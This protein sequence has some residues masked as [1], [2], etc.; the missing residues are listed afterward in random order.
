MGRLA[1][2]GMSFLLGRGRPVGALSC[3]LLGILT[4][5]VTTLADDG[6]LV[7]VERGPHHSVVERRILEPGARPTAGTVQR[8]VQL[9][10]GLN[11]WDESKAS[12]R[13]SVEEVEL[14][15]AGAVAARG[16]YRAQFSPNVNDPQ[17]AARLGFPGAP[18]L[19][20]SVLALRYFDPVTGKDVVLAVVQDAPGGLLAPNQVIY[21]NAFD[22]LQAD[23]LYTY[24]KRGFE[25]DV[26]LREVPPSPGEFGLDPETTR[27]EVLTEFFEAPDPV[28]TPR[29]LASIEDPAWR[30]AVAQPDWVD[31]ELDFGV[32]RMVAGR[33]FAWSAREAAA[34]RPSEFSPVGKRWVRTGDGRTVLIESTEYS[35]LVADL[36]ALPGTP[37]R[38]QELQRTAAAWA[39]RGVAAGKA[40]VLARAAARSSSGARAASNGAGTV[41]VRRWA[42]VER[43]D[44]AGEQWAMGRRE[45]TA[46][47]ERGLVLDWTTL[48]NGLSDF[49]FLGTNT[50]Y[51]TGDCVFTGTTTLEGGAVLKFPKYTNN[52]TGITING[53]WV[54]RASLF[55]PA[56][57]TADTDGTM[58]EIVVA[59]SPD[60][61]ADYGATQLKFLNRGGPIQVEHLRFKY[62]RQ[63]LVFQGDNPDNLVRHCQFVQCRFPVLSTTNTPVRLRNVLVDGVKSLGSIFSGAN[64]PFVGEQLTLHS[65][66]NLLTGGTLVLTNSLVVAVSTVQAYT[67]AG[68]H[69]SASATG[70]FHSQGAGNF[71]LAVGSPHRDAGV[72]EIHAALAQELAQLTTHPPVI[73]TSDFTVDTVLQPQAK[74]DTGLPDRGYHYPPLDYL[75][76]GRMLANVQLRLTNG[77]ALGTYGPVGILLGRGGRLHSAGTPAALNRLVHYGMVQEQAHPTWTLAAGDIALLELVPNTLSPIT[78]ARLVFTDVSMP[79]GPAN[80]R[81][82]LRQPDQGSFALSATHSQVRG[83]DLT[84]MTTQPGVS[85]ALTNSLLEGTSLSL[86]Q[87][88]LVGNQAIDFVAYNNLFRGGAVVLKSDR[89]DST[90]VVRDN[91]F[92]VQTLSVAVTVGTLSHNGFRAGLATFGTSATGG[93]TMDFAAS[94][95]GPYTYPTSGPANSLA[96]LRDA[97]SRGG[98]A[99]GLYLFTTRTDQIPE[100]NSVVDIGFHYAGMG[101]VDTD[102][103]LDVVEDGDG[104][105]VADAGETSYVA[106]DTDYDGRSDFQE[107]QEGTDPLNP[108]SAKPMK[109]ATWTFDNLSDPWKTEAGA[110]P[111]E[112][113]GVGLVETI[114]GFYGAELVSANAVLRYREVEPGG[115]ANINTRQ[116]TIKLTF[117]PYWASALSSC[118]VGTAGTGP[119]TTIELLSVGAFSVAVDPKGTNLMLRSPNGSGGVLTNVQTLL[120]ACVGDIPVDFPLEVQVSYSSNASAIFYNGQLVAR[121]SGIVAWPDAAT[122]ANGLFL[123]T[124]PNRTGQMNGVIDGL[125]TY[126]VPLNMHTNTWIVTAQAGA[127]PLR[128]IL[129]WSGLTNVNYRIERRTVPLTQWVTLA[130]LPPPIYTD[131]TVL[132][133]REYEYRVSADVAVPEEFYAA[134]D[135]AYAT[136]HAGV[137]L[138][139]DDLPGH[140]LLVVDRTLTNNP[141]YEAAVTN[142]TRDL[143][144]EGWVVARYNGPRHDDTTWA[145]NPARIA[146]VK[147]WI[148]S[149][150]NANARLARAVLLFGHLPIPRSG[151][152]RPDAHFYRPFPADTYYADLDGNWTDVGNWPIQPGVEAPNLPGDGIF[153]QEL[154]P[155]NSVGIAGV[156]LAVGRVDFARMPVF[157][158]GSPSRGEVDLLVQYV[159][160]SR[161]FRRRQVTLP[162]RVVYRPY[163]SAT[164]ALDTPEAM[165]LQLNGLPLSM[166]NL[167]ERIDV[168]LTGTNSNAGIYADFF[169]AGQPAIWGIQGG[170]AGGVDWIHSD[171]NVRTLHGITFHSSTNLVSASG[172]PPIAFSLIEMS[173]VGQWD[174]PNHLARALMGTRTN[175]LA[176]LNF[177]TVGTYWKLPMMALGR[178]LGDAYKQTLDDAWTRPFLSFRI[179]PPFGTDVKYYQGIRS[180]GGY[181][182]TA[183]LGDPTLRQS[184]AT[185]VSS[186]TVSTNGSGHLVFQWSPTTDPFP[187]YHLYRT[188]EAIGGKWQRMT[189]SPLQTTNWTDT[190]P[191]VGTRRYM[192]RPLYTKSVASGSY[193]NMGAGTIWP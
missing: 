119:G 43:R 46:N 139:P 37:A 127:S 173:W 126:N 159:N 99:A 188:T 110:D 187:R 84:V 170:Y 107:Y 98:A 147:S 62:G 79:A 172:E 128:V 55:R 10:T 163:F 105:G 118:A 32:H 142:L 109:L 52:V 95:L 156:E 167:G 27:L 160:K 59:G 2:L 42:A 133:G 20:A 9:E 48:I 86:T 25:A 3:L 102:G 125:Q 97:G 35:G 180:Q 12:W 5:V 120:R 61:T 47:L 111:V 8:W 143:A 149:Y 54:N 164:P 31:E 153:D 17:G 56:I 168:A 129:R 41:P 100:T 140:L 89:P 53:T 137:R 72:A 192:V 28:A 21:Q 23:V 132:L 113:T 190:A 193:T 63:A 78:E 49:T 151:M 24:R 45:R 18:E 104:D 87:S 90:W 135:P 74:R 44:G 19:R 11:Y 184:P 181:A 103:I 114:P 116:G 70:L 39:G 67:G 145:N 88:N 175:G 189:L 101:D 7:I 71:Y 15:D 26:V 148:T 150:R 73:V 34:D 92:D 179:S 96:S 166:I 13:E 77:V 138:P 177:G 30:A 174:E 117:A 75:V 85:V 29:L 94:G 83:V 64:T 182:F 80:R 91:L 144:A 60:L 176:F 33:A 69:E 115:A 65:A 106:A 108:T 36:L 76:S 157:A 81:Q 66:P 185:P 82:W 152:V 57:F 134:N 4:N 146:E 178:T 1:A 154:V 68:N 158:S 58:G 51:I 50:Y 191:P 40:Q 165:A 6:A 22:A 162:E 155:T 112:R 93:L 136:V 141:A 169:T 14:T 183:L 123:G 38:L 124:N 171:L 161:A 122:R 16:P 121:G 186:L 131:T 130:S